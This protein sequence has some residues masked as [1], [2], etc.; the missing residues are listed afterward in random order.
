MKRHTEPACDPSRFGHAEP[1]LPDEILPR[2][3]AGID[4]VV[5][6]SL[7]EV[8]AVLDDQDPVQ[9]RPLQHRTPV[10]DDVADAVGRRRS[11]EREIPLVEQGLHARADGCRVDGRAAQLGRREEP[12]RAGHGDGEQRRQQ[13]EPPHPD[14]ISFKPLTLARYWA[15]TTVTP[16]SLS[17]VSCGEVVLQVTVSPAAFVEHV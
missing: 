2:D 11:Q 14:R 8:V 13:S 4:E 17:A 7:E 1:E 15:A 16:V 3:I 6:I 5:V 9:H 12:D 10:E